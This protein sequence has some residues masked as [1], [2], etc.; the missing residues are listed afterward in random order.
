MRLN[1]RD[2]N[3]A[4]HLFAL[5]TAEILLGR[6]DEAIASLQRAS[7]ANPRLWYVHMD[8]AA[9]YGMQ[10]RIDE[11]KRELDESLRLRPEFASLAAIKAAM[12]QYEYLSRL[13]Q[14]QETIFT[15]M[16]RAG[17]PDE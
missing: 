6:S 2:P 17:L 9:A 15:G 11:A 8:L 1:P 14:A 5:G 4:D 10:Q 13:A 16:R 12:P 7:A 3:I